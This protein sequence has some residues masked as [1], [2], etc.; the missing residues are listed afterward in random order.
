MSVLL[1]QVRDRL[2]TLH[3]SLRTEQ[4]YLDWI[5]RYIRHHQ[6]RHPQEMG[7]SEIEAFLTHLAVNRQVSA[8]TQ[9]Q[10]KSALLFLYREVLHI[11]LPW[12]KDV[13]SAKASQRLPVV[14]TPK[15]V[16]QILVEL[17]GVWSLVGR[18]LYGT[19]MR[20]LEGLRLRVKDV[21]FARQEIVVRSGKGDKDRVTMLPANIVTALQ[22]QMADAKAL[23]EGDLAQGWGEVYLPFALAQKYPNA[24]RE[25]AWQ[26]IF[27][28]AQRS[29]DPRSGLIR[30]HHLDEKGMQRAMKQ[31]LQVAGIAKLAT[32]HTLRHSFATHL[33]E[34][35]YDIRTVQALLGHSDVR[36]TMIYTHVLN[37]GGMGVQ[38]PLDRYGVS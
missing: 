15:E 20:L 30:R 1:N 29:A 18:L 5:K 8:S 13:V 33:L 12:L 22:A 17:D 23:H 31:A 27:P 9:N 4:V 25:W 34:A 3:Y 35:G 16:Q 26:Y 11:D 24:N 10:A 28:S 36:T 38:S 32:P 14:L 7:Q 19:G 37:R 21:D 2:R 6:L